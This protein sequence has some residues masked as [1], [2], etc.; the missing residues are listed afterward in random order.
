[1][2]LRHLAA[3]LA[4]FLP[5]LASS[6][7]AFA[8]DRVL[9]QAEYGFSVELPTGPICDSASGGHHH[10]WRAPLN[11][12]CATASRSIIV[13][14]EYNAPFHP[15]PEAAAHCS[16]VDGGSLSDGAKL[17]FSF[18]GRQ[19]AA[20]M[21]KAADGAILISVVTQAGRWPV[22]LSDNPPEFRTP[23]INYT[24][25]LSTT[26]ATLDDDLRLFRRALAS[27]RIAPPMR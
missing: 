6:S 15:S 17:G 22:T 23:W 7:V 16:P 25:H 2:K 4:A 21:T 20:C 11:G 10:G 24:A 26:P 14:A 3:S 5:A 13:L 19:S 12:D 18:A 27:I 8:G 1:M 9:R